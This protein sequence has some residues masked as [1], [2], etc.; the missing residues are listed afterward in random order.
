M[1]EILIQSKPP[2]HQVEETIFHQ[3]R[4][5]KYTLLSCNG[6]KKR[7]IITHYIIGWGSIHAGGVFI[8]T[9]KLSVQFERIY[10]DVSDIMASHLEHSIVINDINQENEKLPEDKINDILSFTSW[11]D[12]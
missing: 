5:L 9:K 12:V 7:K 4:W 11:R 2:F 10:P 6:H 8:F 3:I 1:G